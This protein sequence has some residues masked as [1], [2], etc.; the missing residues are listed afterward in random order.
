MLILTVLALGAFVITFAAI[1]REAGFAEPR[2]DLLVALL[3]VGT[4]EGMILGS[5]LEKV[6]P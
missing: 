1:L 5:L 4:V 6:L 3:I 2:W